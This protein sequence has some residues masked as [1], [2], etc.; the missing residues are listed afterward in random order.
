M[1]GSAPP[2]AL[3]A[4]LRD[5]GVK[6]GDRVAIA[7]RNLPEWPVA[8]FAA[9]AI[10]AIAVPLNA[11]W[12]GA[13]LA[14]ALSDSGCRIVIADAKRWERMRP[15]RDVMDAFD[16]VIVTR[17]GETMGETAG[18]TTFLENIIRSAGQLVHPAPRSIFLKADL[19]PET[20]AFIMYT[21]GTTGKPKGAVGTHRNLLTQHPLDG[22]F[23]CPR[24]AQG[25]ATNLL[26]PAQ[27]VILT[28]IP[29][30]HVTAL[31]AGLMGAMQAG[32]TIIFMHKWDVREAF[33]ASSSASGST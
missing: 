30:F 31:S 23:G 28:V 32:H 8:F 15:E 11:W 16:H 24:R 10:G 9:T 22:I 2:A 33:R 26:R 27:K 20:R 7:M 19:T 5:M 17:A 3:A 6:P 21:S 25:E 29:L 12:T 1:R 13:E 18:E 14:F 4:R